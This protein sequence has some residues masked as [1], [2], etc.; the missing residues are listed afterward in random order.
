MKKINKI[1]NI[2]LIFI[3][4]M[5]FLLPDYAY[6]VNISIAHLRVSLMTTT[7]K[8]LSRLK[9]VMNS[10]SGNQ[11]TLK[12]HRKVD[13]PNYLYPKKREELVQR[14]DL[15]RYNPYPVNPRHLIVHPDEMFDRDVYAK[16]GIQAIMKI[17]GLGIG[18]N[19]IIPGSGGW[20]NSKKVPPS[21]IDAKLAADSPILEKEE[22]GVKVEEFILRSEELILSGGGY[23]Y[24]HWS[25][26]NEV[27]K[28]RIRNNK[29]TV[30]HFPL[31]AIYDYVKG[32]LPDYINS[33]RYIRALLNPYYHGI[34]RLNE[35]LGALEKAGIE[36]STLGNLLFDKG[37]PTAVFYN[38]KRI[39]INS[40]ID[41]NN[42]V[43]II[44]LWD[45]YEM[46]GMQPIKLQDN[47]K[48]FTSL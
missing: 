36:K 14:F 32:T 9:K 31:D 15:T 2:A 43:V 13:Q 10:I 34:L 27:L 45:S 29:R 33:S 8:S 3:L 25:W 17:V 44:N 48:T 11:A 20:I 12:A 5:A 40:Q 28:K 1:I 6:S 21:Y 41:S 37:I 22:D 46:W 47:R 24:C 39:H 38:G 4:I 7:K 19:F 16:P 18:S 26:F 23:E 42:P 35:E 30:L